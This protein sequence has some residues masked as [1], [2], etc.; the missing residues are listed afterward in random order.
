MGLCNA[1]NNELRED[2][3]TIETTGT[4]EEGHGSS[5]G[6][7]L[8]LRSHSTGTPILAIRGYSSLLAKTSVSSRIRMVHLGT[9]WIALINLNTDQ[10]SKMGTF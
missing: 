8:S 5:D 10:K 4:P 3:E 1:M 2:T 6:D 7:R 9:A